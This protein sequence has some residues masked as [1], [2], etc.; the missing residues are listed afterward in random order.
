MKVSII[1][2][3]YNEATTIAELLEKVR[4]AP[5]SIDREIIVVDDGS[6]DGTSSIL[7]ALPDVIRISH[8]VNRGKGAALR[9]GIAATTGNFVLIQDAD[10]EYDPTDYHKLLS[11]LIANSADVVYGS[12]FLEPRNT[13]RLHTYL[14]NRFLSWL[15]RL[16]TPLPIT[17]MESCYKTFRL[18][19][20]R[21]LQLTEDRFGIEPELTV[22]MARIPGI[23]YAEVP[24]SY[25]GRSR[26][27]GKKI[28]WYDGLKAITAL[29]WYRFNRKTCA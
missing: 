25:R 11:P 23:R 29:F 16:L 5:L 15:T 13:Y 28:R 19:I 21:S 14:A 18:P 6:T 17:D 12:R 24:I 8:S 9:T 3:V 26:R 22:K 27:Q 2:P 7:A 10:L 1:I 20:I 4:T